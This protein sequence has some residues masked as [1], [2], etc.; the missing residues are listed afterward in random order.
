MPGCDTPEQ[1]LDGYPRQLSYGVLRNS[2]AMLAIASQLAAIVTGDQR[3]MV[4]VRAIHVDF[5][6]CLPISGSS[7]VVPVRRVQP[8][9]LRVEN[10]T[11]FAHG[12]RQIWAELEEPLLLVTAQMSNWKPNRHAVHQLAP[13]L[14]NRYHG[15]TVSIA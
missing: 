10:P 1:M 8:F 12:Q 4:P 5:T 2:N 15:R 13:M 7:S 11:L 6:D 3:N 14:F 9:S